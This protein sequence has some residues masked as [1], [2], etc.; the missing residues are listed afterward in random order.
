MPQLILNGRAIPLDR[1]IFRVGRDAQFN[2]LTLDDTKASRYH[3]VFVQLGSGRVAVIDR[4]S[5]N[6]TKVNGRRVDIAHL[7][8]RDQVQIGGSQLTFGY[9]D[10]ESEAPPLPESKP[11]RARTV[12]DDEG[13][14]VIH[15]QLSTAPPCEDLREAETQEAIP[16]DPLGLYLASEA[17]PKRG[18]ERVL[19]RLLENR[20]DCFA[21]AA[22]GD[23]VQGVW[24]RVDSRDRFPVLNPELAPGKTQGAVDR[25]LMRCRLAQG[26]VQE[27]PLLSI[28]RSLSEIWN[29]TQLPSF[30]EVQEM[31]AA[32]VKIDTPK[33]ECILG[34]FSGSQ[35]AID[36][37]ILLHEIRRV[38]ASIETWMQKSPVRIFAYGS[39][40][41]AEQMQER[42][43]SARRLEVAMLS[44]YRLTFDHPGTFRPGGVAGLAT[45]GGERV[46]GVIWE[47]QGRD[48]LFLDEREKS[49]LRRRVRVH[50]LDGKPYLAEAYFTKPELVVPG[51][52]IPPDP[53]Y[54]DLVLR[55]AS[56]AGLPAPYV[57]FL[58]SF[59]VHA[60]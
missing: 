42:C 17:D 56:E 22:M 14:S 10:E 51:N 36:G 9:Q 39:N 31:L 55:G 2:D 58:E 12:L 49:Y 23:A 11:D 32:G 29:T 25:F 4:N 5:S 24:L 54:L 40:L 43:P 21:V 28:D 1:E 18:L 37:S 30:G 57:R 6:G 47:L 59:R 48:L 35:K 7:E 34:L 27:G 38:S 41:L 13:I 52:A 33:G 45:Q 16:A 20:S 19:M 46:Y 8:P 53:E 60:A 44:D 15:A 3:A 26:P 50:S